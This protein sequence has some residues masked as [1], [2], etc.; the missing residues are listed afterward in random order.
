MKKYKKYIFLYMIIQIGIWGSNPLEEYITD[1]VY[2]ASQKRFSYKKS[3]F[4]EKIYS[5]AAIKKERAEAIKK[6]EAIFLRTVFI[7]KNTTGEWISTFYYKNELG[8]E[9]RKT[10]IKREKMKIGKSFYLV[11]AYSEGIK[12]K[13]L[14][15][16]YEIKIKRKGR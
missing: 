15:T 16:R 9:K 10:I 8:E 2:K 6:M 11:T 7:S 13:D 1:E 3:I 14:K 4:E 12:V 5:M